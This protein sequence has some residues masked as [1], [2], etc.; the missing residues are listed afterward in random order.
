[1]DLRLVWMLLEL[2]RQPR[3]LR[4]FGSVP[5]QAIAWQGRLAGCSPACFLVS[6]QLY[7]LLA[8]VRSSS[9]IPRALI[10]DISLQWV[11]PSLQQ[12]EHL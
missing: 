6:V 7:R 5:E 10:D 3:R 8:G 2:Y 4:A 9:V 1:M 11:A 12:L